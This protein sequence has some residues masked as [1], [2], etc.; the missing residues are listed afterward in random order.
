MVGLVV[1]YRRRSWRTCR[2]R[3]RLCRWAFW[4]LLWFLGECL[5]RRFEF[6]SV[7]MMILKI[8]RSGWFFYVFL[9]CYAT[10]KSHA[11]L[12][13]SYDV[14]LAYARIV[15]SGANQRVLISKHFPEPCR[16]GSSL[17]KFV[18][19]RRYAP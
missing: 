12:A 19:I 10:D 18:V 5:M 7:R 15:S 2:S 17:M 13:S 16:T 11:S 8:Q 3:W 6:L 14:L 9:T 4:D 1:A